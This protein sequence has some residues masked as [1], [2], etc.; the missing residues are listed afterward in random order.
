MKTG[1]SLIPYIL[2]MFKKKKGKKK[3][4]RKKREKINSARKVKP[5]SEAEPQST[6]TLKNLQPF[7]FQ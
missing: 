6:V 3:K 5:S 4:G 1:G 2:K 7:T